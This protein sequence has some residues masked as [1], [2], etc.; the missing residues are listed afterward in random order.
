MLLRSFATE[1]SNSHFEMIGIATFFEEEDQFLLHGFAPA[2]D[3]KFKN[4]STSIRPLSEEGLYIGAVCLE[5]LKRLPSLTGADDYKKAFLG[6]Y[7]F[8]QRQM[9]TLMK[10]AEK[11]ARMPEFPTPFNRQT[12][13]SYLLLHKDGKFFGGFDENGDVLLNAKHFEPNHKKAFIDFVKWCEHHEHG[14]K[15]CKHMIAKRHGLIASTMDNW[16]RNDPVIK[17]E[18]GE[19][20]ASPLNQSRNTSS[21]LM[22][23]PTH[24][25]I[26]GTS[27]SSIVP[28]LDVLNENLQLARKSVDLSERMLS[29]ANGSSDIT[30]QLIKDLKMLLVCEARVC[31]SMTNKKKKIEILERQRLIA[32]KL[33]NHGVADAT[34]LMLNIM[35]EERCIVISLLDPDSNIVADGSV[36]G[37]TS[38]DEP[39]TDE[40]K[41]MTKGAVNVATAIDETTTDKNEHSTASWTQNGTPS[42]H[43]PAIDETT[44]DKTNSIHEPATDEAKQMTKGA[45]N[46]A[47]AIEEPATDKITA[48][49]T[50]N[51]AALENI[52]L[53]LLSFTTRYVGNSLISN[54]ATILSHVP[55]SSSPPL[56]ARIYLPE[57]SRLEEPLQETLCW[58]YPRN[59]RLSVHQ[60]F[61]RSFC[62]FLQLCSDVKH[63]FDLLPSSALFPRLIV[64][65]PSILEEN[66]FLRRMRPTLGS[67]KRLLEVYQW[68]TEMVW[69][70][71][72]PFLQCLVIDIEGIFKQSLSDDIFVECT[73]VFFH[74]T[75]SIPGGPLLSLREPLEMG[76]AATK[77]R[78]IMM[79]PSDHLVDG[80]GIALNEAA[81]FTM[82]LSEGDVLI[83]KDDYIGAC[84]FGC[85]KYIDIQFK[86]NNK[87]PIPKGKRKRKSASS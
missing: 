40:A 56:I 47:T 4:F 35:R 34:E 73:N 55:T 82:N 83:F 58:Q 77:Y 87:H 68:F 38:I 36:V 25:Y 45:V 18:E 50:N 39:A 46:V 61:L 64:W 71:F 13:G 43:E 42:I 5:R 76:S 8:K 37:T 78:C 26:S 28:S 44:T 66:N 75:N 23:S 51:G 79:L 32:D 9:N 81:K 21:K 65:P 29:L 22:R 16:F 3:G 33:I 84:H 11:N 62:E 53:S 70:N 27:S 12:D 10:T 74:W 57:P 6:R 59:E 54:P 7:G 41:Q 72:V 69:P 2:A 85:N 67:G 20:W 49:L 30:D 15:V 60:N 86:F 48:S 31:E 1:K 63:F 52:A 19:S 17:E 80:L 14:Y 24:E